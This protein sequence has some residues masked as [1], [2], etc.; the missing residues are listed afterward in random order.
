M[1]IE[2]DWGNRSEILSRNGQEG[3]SYNKKGSSKAE[4][5]IAGSSTRESQS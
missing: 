5:G 3:D 2:T 1:H 4:S